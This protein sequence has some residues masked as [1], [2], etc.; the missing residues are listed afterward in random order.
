MG[1]NNA[2]SA[3]RRREPYNQPIKIYGAAGSESAPSL[4]EIMERLRH[5][6]R[7]ARQNRNI[8]ARVG[9]DIEY[10]RMRASLS[11]EQAAGRLKMTPARLKRI[12]AG[13]EKL[14]LSLLHRIAAALGCYLQVE[15]V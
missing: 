8:D 9:S 5:A 7:G 10:R 1:R 14:T 3:E 12:E 13:K 11:I 2:D 15:L 6:R 4:R